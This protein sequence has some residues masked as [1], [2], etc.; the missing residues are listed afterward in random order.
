VAISR[1]KEVALLQ[2]EPG[3]VHT[4]VGVTAIFV[5][6][7]GGNVGCGATEVAEPKSQPTAVKVRVSIPVRK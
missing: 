7:S 5:V 4:S 6:P 3:S 1:S 2:R